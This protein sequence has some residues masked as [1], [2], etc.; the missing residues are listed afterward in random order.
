MLIKRVILASMLILSANVVLA[1]SFMATCPSVDMLKSFDGDLIHTFPTGIDPNKGMIM[2]IIQNRNFTHD[3]GVF[4][5]YG[6]LIFIMSGVVI[7]SG[8]DPEVNAHVLLAN[9]QL[10]TDTPFTYRAFKD[11]VIP[12]CAYSLPDDPSV[13][14]VVYQVPDYKKPSFG[15]V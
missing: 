5:G 11:T 7:H 14:A 10:D 13:K 12:V 8:E 3:A 6:K 9:M 4:A 1:G 15:I 2:S